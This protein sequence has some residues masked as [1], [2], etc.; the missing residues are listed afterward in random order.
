VGEFGR[1]LILYR[2]AVCH[3]GLHQYAECIRYATESLGVQQGAG[4]RLSEAW[5]LDVQAKAL[6]ATGHASAACQSWERALAIL[7]EAGHPDAIKI[8][9]NL[10][11]ADGHSHQAEPEG[12]TSP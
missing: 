1:G 11:N 6:H 5:T 12:G 8:R 10:A 9:A 3:L 7:E 2:L 4:D